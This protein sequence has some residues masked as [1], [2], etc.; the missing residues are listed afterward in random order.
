[1]RVFP[2]KPVTPKLIVRGGSRTSR[3]TGHQFID[4][5]VD[6][7]F[8]KFSERPNEIKKKISVCKGCGSTTEHEKDMEYRSIYVLFYLRA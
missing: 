3:R 4:G 6:H 2:R 1:M 7:I 8:L 5:S